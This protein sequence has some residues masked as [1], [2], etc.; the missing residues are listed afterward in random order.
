MNVPHLCHA[1]VHAVATNRDPMLRVLCD[2]LE[3]VTV[4]WPRRHIQQNFHRQ[5]FHV[6]INLSKVDVAIVCF[7]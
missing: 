7:E 5:G 6:P 4:R 3:Q 1:Q 2:F